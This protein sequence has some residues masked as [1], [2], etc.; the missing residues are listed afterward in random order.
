M[1]TPWYWSHISGTGKPDA[2]L[3]MLGLVR[4]MLGSIITVWSDPFIH[5]GKL[6]HYPCITKLWVVYF[7]SQVWNLL[8]VV[9]YQALE[10]KRQFRMEE[11]LEVLQ[12]FGENKRLLLRLLM[13]RPCSRQ[14]Y[15]KKHLAGQYPLHFAP[16][17]FTAKHASQTWS[18]DRWVHNKH[19]FDTNA[20]A[21]EA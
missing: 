11:T 21:L 18:C 12:H 4:A 5:A 8:A 20:T 7:M 10:A 3:E 1:G 16:A 2:L 17:W 6:K 9:R 14:Q 15:I 19:S 13:Q